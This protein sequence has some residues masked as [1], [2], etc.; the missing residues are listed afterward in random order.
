MRVADVQ[1]LFCANRNF[2]FGAADSAAADRQLFFPAGQ[3]LIEFK[4][5]VLDQLRIETAIC[6]KVYVFKENAEHLR[7]N[8]RA[9][10]AGIYGNHGGRLLRL[11]EK[12][13]RQSG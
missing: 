8:C 3:W 2:A 13:Y 5:S 6:A 10:V 4:G 1:R 11:R 9:G 7:R 12:V